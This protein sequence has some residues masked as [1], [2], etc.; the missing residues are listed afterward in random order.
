MPPLLETETE[1][2]S[3]CGEQIPVDRYELHVRGL[4][5]ARPACP[6]QDL[7]EIAQ[8]ARGEF[9]QFGD[10]RKRYLW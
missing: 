4:D 2:C 8:R 6:K 5:G 7:V 10:R 9:D 3:S 1:F